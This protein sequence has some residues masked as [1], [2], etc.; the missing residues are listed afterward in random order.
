MSIKTIIHVDYVLKSFSFLWNISTSSVR[1]GL[2]FISGGFINDFARNSSTPIVLE[3]IDS[4][5]LF[6]PSLSEFCSGMLSEQN[7]TYSQDFFKKL[8]NPNPLT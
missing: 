5:S 2:L 4:L 7:H 3:F 6:G 8:T 1:L